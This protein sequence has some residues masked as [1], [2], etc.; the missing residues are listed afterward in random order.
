MDLSGQIQ[1]VINVSSVNILHSVNNDK[2]LCVYSKED[3]DKTMS[4]L[5][6]T[7]GSLYDCERFPFHPVAVSS[8]DVGNIIL[9]VDGCIW[10]ADRDGKTLKSLYHQW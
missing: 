8:D 4:C 5:V 1:R 9:T 3:S 6:Y 7:N 10:Q 2:K